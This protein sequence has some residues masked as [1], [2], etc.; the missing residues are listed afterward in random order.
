ML[1]GH[2][3]VPTAAR[4]TGMTT[5]Q[6]YE[7]IDQEELAAVRDRN[8]MVVIPVDALASIGS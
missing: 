2:V 6:L 7:L 5:R 8:G 1:P 4:M 3:R